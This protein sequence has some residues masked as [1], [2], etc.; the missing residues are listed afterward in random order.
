MGKCSCVLTHTMELL[1]FSVVAIALWVRNSN[2]KISIY[3]LQTPTALILE[4]P[5]QARGSGHAVPAP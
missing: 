4:A 1:T 2:E 3:Y 5:R